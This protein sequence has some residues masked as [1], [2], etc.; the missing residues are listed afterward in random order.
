[1]GN[2]FQSSILQTSFGGNPQVKHLTKR[3]LF[4]CLVKLVKMQQLLLPKRQHVSLDG[5]W[6]KVTED[7]CWEQPTKE[8]RLYL[9]YL[10][11]R[12]FGSC[13]LIRLS[14]FKTVPGTPLFSTAN[15]NSLWRRDPD[16]DIFSRGGRWGRGWGR[17]FHRRLNHFQK[18]WSS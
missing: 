9:R 7:C 5:S 2:S 13:A 12:S 6:A 10:I 11:L 14:P 4:C 18:T 15:K 3:K 8:G 16:D 1:M 17:R